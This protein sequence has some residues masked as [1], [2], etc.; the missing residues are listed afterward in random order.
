MRERRWKNKSSGP[1]V[2]CR[3]LLRCE[4]AGE[5]AGRRVLCAGATAVGV[6]GSKA[7]STLVSVSRACPRSFGLWRG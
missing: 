2:F 3:L 6:A 5:G 1:V 4:D 7:G